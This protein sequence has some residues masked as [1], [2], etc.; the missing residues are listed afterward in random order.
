V[1]VVSEQIELSNKGIKFSYHRF[2]ADSSAGMI[3][4]LLVLFFDKKYQLGIL[5]SFKEQ[6]VKMFIVVLLF[7]L[8]TPIGL[9]INA[10]SW[11]TVGPLVDLCEEFF[12]TKLQLGEEYL[13][14]NLLKIDLGLKENNLRY[15]SSMFKSMIRHMELETSFELGHIEGIKKFFR[16]LSFIFFTLSILLFYSSKISI[17]H[18]VLLVITAYVFAF[19]SGAIQY[20]EYA[21]IMREIYI[22]SLEKKGFKDDLSSKIKKMSENINQIERDSKNFSPYSS[23]IKLSFLL[24]F[25]IIPFYIFLQSMKIL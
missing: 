22:I 23:L 20:F 5:N 2:I 24:L 14:Y 3:L 10:M 7:F 17:Y 12:F 8:A 18:F 6:E 4:I 15:Y 16:N 13:L 9:S 21:T 19:A 25:F 1:V 11:S